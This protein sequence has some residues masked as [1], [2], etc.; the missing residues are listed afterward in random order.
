VARYLLHRG[1]ELKLTKLKSA[2]L[3]ADQ[4]AALR[5]IFL[6]PPVHQF[7]GSGC[8]CSHR[9]EFVNR[10]GGHGDSAAGPKLHIDPATTIDATSWTVHIIQ[11]NMDS[12]YS[13]LEAAE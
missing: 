3:H 9:C 1:C 8:S 12:S 10:Q 7:A 2:V 11:P 5:T 13:A 6:Y 4:L